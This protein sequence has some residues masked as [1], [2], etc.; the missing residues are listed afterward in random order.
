MTRL[1]NI[2][3]SPMISSTMPTAPK[4]GLIIHDDTPGET[5]VGH[6]YLKS[7]QRYLREQ[8]IDSDSWSLSHHDEP[9]RYSAYNSE[10]NPAFDE[11]VQIQKT[12]NTK[13]PNFADNDAQGKEARRQRN[14]EEERLTR[15]LI[16]KSDVVALSQI[17][18]A[19]EEV[20]EWL[21][22]ARVQEARWAAEEED[23][24]RLLAWA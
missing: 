14:L 23:G 2:R 18:G 6:E 13:Y 5:T 7:V 17:P 20:E 1:F 24:P 10:G 3:T 21:Q 16:E 15:A 19:T 8:G 11:A 22:R 4:F 12:V 9:G